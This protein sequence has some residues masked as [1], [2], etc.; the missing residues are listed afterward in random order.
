MGL[1]FEI[2]IAALCVFGLW[3][4]LRL[5]AEAL[6]VSRRV[7]TAIL[8]RGRDDVEELASL[9]SQARTMLSYRKGCRVVILCDY[10]LL[11]DEA[12]KAHIL[13]LCEHCDAELWSGEVRS[14]V[15]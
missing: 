5:C 12:L 6:F 14:Q 11:E 2:L 7:T 13:S 9:I 8:L 4:L 3:C 15:R 10:K 1:F